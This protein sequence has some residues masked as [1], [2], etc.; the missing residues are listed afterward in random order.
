M[1]G[2]HITPPRWCRYQSLR[3]HTL[4]GHSIDTLAIY[5]HWFLHYPPATIII[6]HNIFIV[7]SWGYL[8]T[9]VL[10]VIGIL[11]AARYYYQHYDITPFILSYWP[12][13]HYQYAA[14]RRPLNIVVRH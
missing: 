13:G 1:G 11:A 12:A 10:Y 6:G 5:Y 2:R 3:F 14:R 9:L 7:I 4:V 8:P